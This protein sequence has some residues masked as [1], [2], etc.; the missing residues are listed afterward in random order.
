MVN[1][2]YLF[3]WETS[4]EFRKQSKSLNTPKISLL[5][6]PPLTIIQD[7]DSRHGNPYLLAV[8]NCPFSIFTRP[9]YVLYQL[10]LFSISQKVNWRNIES[11]LGIN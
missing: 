10:F 6:Q 1:Y 3:W 2:E 8:F 11:H 9:K 4:Q 7:H 5:P